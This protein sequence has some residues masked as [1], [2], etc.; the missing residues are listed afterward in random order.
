MKRGLMV[1]VAALAAGLMLLGGCSCGGG[2]T[3]ETGGGETG[4]G[5]AQL[6]GSPSFAVTA[7]DKDGDN[8]NVTVNNA[9]VVSGIT[10]DNGAVELPAYKPRTG[11]PKPYLEAAGPDGETLL[12]DI[13]AAVKAV[14]GGGSIPAPAGEVKAL[15]FG[16]I[17]VSVIQPRDNSGSRSGSGSSRQPRERADRAQ[18][19]TGASRTGEAGGSEAGSGSSSTT[20]R[21]PTILATVVLNDNLK[22]TGIRLMA[23]RN[24]EKTFFVSWPSRRV[25]RKY[26]PSVSISD[27][28]LR[29]KIEE[30]LLKAYALQE[31]LEPE[32]LKLSQR[33]SGGAGEEGEEGGSPAG[34]VFISAIAKD[35]DNFTATL[36][37]EIVISGIS[38]S[39]GVKFP[40]SESRP[41]DGG[42]AKFFPHVRAPFR[43]A[44]TAVERLQ[45]AIEA[46]AEN[47]SFEKG[48][49]AEL[50]VSNVHISR[51]FADVTF[52]NAIAIHGFKITGRGAEATVSLPSVKRGSSYEPVISF[53]TES[54]W[55]K[56]QAQIIDKF[57]SMPERS[58]TGSGSRRSSGGSRR[59]NSDGGGEE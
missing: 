12:S 15:E 3:T 31:G 42:E 53:R 27:D 52:N 43:T 34:D 16:S 23:D 32:S 26:E 37:N 51:G 29:V 49:A 33:S 55:K 41:R 39:D 10:C 4:G 28:A 21:Q 8:F 50:A 6:Q 58:N 7:C 44:A 36:W 17:E 56:I 11:S 38:I 18:A 54:V 35:G 45:T 1:L 30:E 40:G 24:A 47:G 5:V 59:S 46:F 57:S 13:E 48:A 14:A 20:P 22:V 25:G 9:L 19:R 2:G